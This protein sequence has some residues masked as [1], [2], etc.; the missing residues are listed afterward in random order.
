MRVL[1]LC[2]KVPFP[3]ADGGSIAMHQITKG[4]WKAGFQVKVIALNLK[5]CQVCPENIPHDYREKTEFEAQTID[6]RIKPIQAFLNLFTRESY[7]VARFYSK[8]MERRLE[9]TLQNETFDIIQ[10]EGLYLTPYIP[11]I[12]KYSGAKL[13]YRSHNIEHFIWERMAKV[14]RNPLK[15]WYLKLLASRLKRYEMQAIRQV[16]ALVAISPVDLSFFQNN[17]FSKPALVVPVTMPRLLFQDEKPEIKTGTV[18][19]LGSMDWR[20]NQEG[21]EWF[22]EEVW[23]LVIKEVPGMKF[24]LAGKRLPPRYF[25]YASNNVV[26][27][28]EVPS[29]VEFMSDKQIMV[30]PLLSGGGMRVKIIEGMAAG[31]T[32]IS[33]RIGAEGI[34]CEDRKH[35]L[36]ADEPREMARLIIQ[37]QQEPEFANQLGEAAML[38]VEKNFSADSVM[39]GLIKFYEELVENKGY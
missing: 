23:P 7:N 15:K 14:A 17:G 22:L 19:H 28:G 18:F 10:L 9:K 2:H 31:K 8:A 11:V 37:C 29:A 35:I 27:A 33:T 5:G 1:Q 21:I 30:V 6:T 39:P 36:L 25:R 13:V 4:L 38:F 3:P 32:I 24:F 20:P 16:D 12:R 34:G 26:V